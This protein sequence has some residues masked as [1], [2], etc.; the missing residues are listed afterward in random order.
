MCNTTQE[1]FA[2]TCGISVPNALVWCERAFNVDVSLITF[3]TVFYLTAL[4]EIKSAMRRYE[5]ML[6]GKYSDLPPKLP[7]EVRIFL[8]STFSGFCSNFVIS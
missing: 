8:S 1:E 7:S 4:P 2:L 6:R 5:D 3:C